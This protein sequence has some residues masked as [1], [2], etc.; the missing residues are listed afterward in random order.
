MTMIAE[1]KSEV[2]VNAGFLVIV[3]GL[4][5]LRGAEGA[6]VVAGILAIV[7]VGI[8]VAWLSWRRKPAPML[9]ISPEE[10]FYGRLD[11]P[12]MRISREASPSGRLRFHMG[13]QRSGWVL[14]LAD[15][16][17]QPGISMIGFDMRE[18]ERACVEH[19]WTFA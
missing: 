1:K 6:P 15:A 8:L 3:L 16:P 17:G 10:I 9:A 5:A 7:A 11:Q 18:V 4:A 19:S 13:F 2:D 14:A 12:G